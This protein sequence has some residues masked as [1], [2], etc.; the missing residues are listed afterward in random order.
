MRLLEGRDHRRR[1]RDGGGSARAAPWPRSCWTRLPPV[2]APAGPPA[3]DVQ[4]TVPVPAEGALVERGALHRRR[5]R[6]GGEQGPELEGGGGQGADAEAELGGDRGPDDRVGEAA[7]QLGAEQEPEVAEAADHGEEAGGE[8]E[9]EQA[10]LEPPPE[11]LAD[12]QGGQDPPGRRGPEPEQL[13][14]QRGPG[15]DPGAGQLDQVEGHHQGE[16]GDQ[17]AQPAAAPAGRHHR[18]GQQCGPGQPWQRRRPRHPADLADHVG[19]AP[20]G[21]ELH[22]PFGNGHL[23]RPGRPPDLGGRL[24]GLPVGAVVVPG[25]GLAGLDPQPGLARVAEHHHL[26]GRSGCGGAAGC[27]RRPPR[28]RPPP[29]P[30]ARPGPGSGS[31]SARPR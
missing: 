12:G 13:A 19:E 21:A 4:L 9:L 7:G 28:P 16:G 8:Q 10:A 3:D 5:L 27:R 26:A 18:H 17:G 24:L 29:G 1:S 23:G 6:L 22:G 20:A 2:P 30:A 25:G 31:C 11:Q 15:A 14:G